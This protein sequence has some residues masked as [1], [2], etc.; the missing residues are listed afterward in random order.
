MRA[1]AVNRF[2]G[3]DELVGVELPTPEA[4]PDGVLIRVEAAGVGPWD[5]MSREGLFGE[6]EFPYVPGFEVA[7]VVEA[8]GERVE[9]FSAGDEV[10]AYNF[11]GGGYAEYVAAPAIVSARKPAS[12][13]FEEAASVP[14]A[15]TTAHQGLVDELGLREGETVLVTGAAGGVG[16][17]AVQLAANV[18]GARVIGT[19]SPRNHG[20]VRS[21]GAS[22]VVDYHEGDWV[23]A[24][25][26]AAPE[27]VDAVLECVGGETLER[28][29]AAVRDGGRV[30]YIV[31][32]DGQ[33][34]A[35]RGIGARFFSS[36]PDGSRLAKLAGLFDEG[37]IRTNLQE[38]LPLEEAALA[39]ERIEGRHTRGKIVLCV[40]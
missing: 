39:H 3:R 6:R 34:R 40:A 24:V 33:P 7:G 11:P 15:G 23:A 35:P 5:V 25:R 32:A 14:V 13:S 10:Y 2:G 16:S 31:P 18:L 21:L 37:R 30:A 26:Q 12:L 28:S 4:R 27:G 9:Q 36:A 29:L 22:A 19:A 8:V 17:F 20:Y 1:V 38:V